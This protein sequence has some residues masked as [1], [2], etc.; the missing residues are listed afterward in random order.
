MRGWES[1]CNASRLAASVLMKAWGGV[2]VEAGTGVILLALRDRDM[3]DFPILVLSR[4]E[5]SQ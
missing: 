1:I 4:L 3:W 2:V 5:I